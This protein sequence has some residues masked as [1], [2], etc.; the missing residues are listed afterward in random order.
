MGPTI[1]SP[2]SLAL[3]KLSPLGN[4]TWRIQVPD[5]TIP[6]QPS[7]FESI[8]N[9]LD[10]ETLDPRAIEYQLHTTLASI[11]AKTLSYIS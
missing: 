1:L 6:N 7:Y 4:Q 3:A 2:T 8:D 10:A 5:W 9:K 11:G